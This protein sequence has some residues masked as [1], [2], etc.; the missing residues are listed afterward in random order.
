MNDV[1]WRH[2]PCGVSES[3][4]TS[5]SGIQPDFLKYEFTVINSNKI[6][7]W[8]FSRMCYAIMLE[9]FGWTHQWSCMIPTLVPST[10]FCRKQTESCLSIRLDI[11]FS[12]QL[13]QICTYICQQTWLPPNERN[14]RKPMPCYSIGQSQYS[15]GWLNGGC[16]VR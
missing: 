8:D 14:S 1:I 9:F 13:T 3:T 6:C 11:Q 12:R 2:Q 5:R 4:P 15:N 7:F 10:K 16:C